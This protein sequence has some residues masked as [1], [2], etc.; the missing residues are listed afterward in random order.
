MTETKYLKSLKFLSA[1]LWL[2]GLG[3]I[4]YKV[5]ILVAI[6]FILLIVGNNFS[7]VYIRS[8]TKALEDE[9]QS[10]DK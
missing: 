1:F 5:G 7:S 8:Q 9:E 4:T 10:E 3:I 6:A 2:A